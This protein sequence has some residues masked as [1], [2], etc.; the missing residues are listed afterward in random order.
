VDPAERRRCLSDKLSRSAG[1]LG[2][3]VVEDP[4]LLEEVADLVEW[5]GV[6]AGHFDGGFLELPRELLVTTLRHHQKCFSVKRPDGELLP[7]FLAVANTDRDPAGHVRRGNEWVIGGRLEDARFFWREDRKR[8]LA[9]RSPDL[10]K[11]VLHAE[12]GSY[13]EKAT[14]MEALA[15][16]IAERLSLSDEQSRHCAAAA[17]LAKNDLV[18]GT[19]GEFP[20]LQGRIGG[21]LLEAE[22]QPAPLARAVYEHY[23]P[24][25]P[26]DGVPSSV[27]GSVVAL[28]DKLDALAEFVR[29]GKT[30][31]GSRDPFGLRRATS[32]ILRIVLERG[33]GLSVD[34][35]C[36][37]AG[38][39]R[40]LRGF[41]TERLENFFRDLS[42]TANEIRS[43][44]RVDAGAAGT[45]VP[46]VE[47][48]IRLDAVRRVRERPDFAHLVDLTKRIY[49]IIPQTS[50]QVLAKLDDDWAPTPDNYEAFDE[51][52]EAGRALR[53]LIAELGPS[54]QAKAGSKRYDEVIDLLA[55][56]VDPVERFFEDVLVIDSK[57]PD[58]TYH[59]REMLVRLGGVL[60]RYFDI[61]ELA[62]DAERRTQWPS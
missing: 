3:R 1:E 6:V 22:G 47:V 9:E 21:L 10:Y 30:P 36:S 46:L 56:F 51:P 28:A 58:E 25:G 61:R 57:Q 32:G 44:V 17:T 29:I 16:R 39:T 53:G 34:D 7:S 4:E 14:R 52:K 27:E 18:T 54:I 15:R 55:R 60:T 26:D 35:L 5:P 38:G 13:A 33:W 24:V 19:V 37:L 11:V 49:N 23:Q 20:E 45:R 2:G 62:G 48:K 40:G 8:S 31:T 59:R 50:D 42:Y 12:L 41:L 43:V